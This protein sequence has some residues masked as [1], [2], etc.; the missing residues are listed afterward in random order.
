MTW[1]DL[2]ESPN[3]L[4]RHSF[5][6]NCVILW[7]I[8][9]GEE[10][11][12]FSFQ[13]FFL[14]SNSRP[15]PHLGSDLFL[16]CVL[17]ILPS[18]NFKMGET[19]H[20]YMF[21]PTGSS[22]CAMHCIVKVWGLPLFGVSW[23]TVQITSTRILTSVMATVYVYVRSSGHQSATYYRRRGVK[24]SLLWSEVT[25]RCDHWYTSDTLAQGL[26]QILCYILMHK[27]MYK[28]C[29]CCIALHYIALHCIALHCIA[30]VWYS[31]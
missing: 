22:Q 6:V 17:W 7:L 15:Q 9:L 8:N 27:Y 3:L 31:G 29:Q 24:G 26:H 25:G 14:K 1:G 12:L 10:E 21:K 11:H 18:R 2:Y 23:V 30:C 5:S 16:D 4:K 28:P 20:Y 13:S 19:T